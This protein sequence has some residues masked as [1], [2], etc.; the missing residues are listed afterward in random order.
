MESGG[1]ETPCDMRL[2]VTSTNVSLQ[3]V[4]QTTAE[5]AIVGKEP[6]PPCYVQCKVAGV[7]PKYIPNTEN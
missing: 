2:Q 6:H 3:S 1:S 7:H 5:I 4:V